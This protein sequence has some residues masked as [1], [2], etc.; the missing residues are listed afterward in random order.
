MLNPLKIGSPKIVS[1]VLMLALI[2]PIQASSKLLLVA[3][4]S[5]VI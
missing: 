3:R 5:R 1:K 4:S 2:S